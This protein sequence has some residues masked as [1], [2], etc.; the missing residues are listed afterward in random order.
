MRRC[1]RSLAVAFIL[2]F[3]CACGDADEV[4]TTPRCPN[5]GER[6]EDA[7]C[8]ENDGGAGGGD[9]GGRCP[10]G[11]RPDGAEGCLDAG[12]RDDGCSA[13]ESATPDGCEPAGVPQDAC[14]AG[15]LWVDRSCA[16]ILP[17]EPCPKGEIAQLGQIACTEVASCGVGTW[18]DIAV[19]ASSIYV[20]GSH[21]GQST[22]SASQP[23]K[24]IQAAVDAA[25]GGETIAIAAGTYDEDVE[26]EGKTVHLWGRCP[27][28]VE[29]RG[30]ATGNA[31]LFFRAGAHDSSVHTLAVT[32]GAIGVLASGSENLVLDRLWVH[33]TASRGINAQN[34]FGVTGITVRESLVE[35]VGAV[36]IF[37]GASGGIVEGTTVRAVLS[38]SNLTLGRGIV[39][40]YLPET[41]TRA[42]ATISSTVVDT[43][44]DT[45]IFVVGSDTT[46]D[47]TL[48][49]NTLPNELDDRTGR[50]IAVQH[51]F[52]AAERG[53]LTLTRSVI[54]DNR[55]VGFFV[56][57]SDA[58]VDASVIASTQPDEADQ[59]AGGGLQVRYD[60]DKSF[61]ASSLVMS[62]SVVAD[63]HHVGVLVEGSTAEIRSSIVRSTKPQA[64]DQLFGRGIE[65]EDVAEVSIRTSGIVEGSL[66]EDS[67]EM[68]VFAG[69]SDLHIEGT[70][71]RNTQ[72]AAADASLGRGVAAEA[73]L[74]TLAA[75]SLTV[76]A[77]VIEE[78]H[79]L[80]VFISGATA[81]IHGTLIQNIDGARAAAIPGRGVSLQNDAEA[82]RS[83]LSMDSSVVSDVAG[84][85][86]FCDASDLVL[87]GNEIS[88][89]GSRGVNVQSGLEAGSL[90]VVDT[91]V[92]DATEIGIYAEGSTVD[93]MG[94]TVRD[95]GAEP[96]GSFGDGIV[97]VNAPP[98]FGAAVTETAVL[99]SERAAVAAFGA[100]VA[101]QSCT[102]ECNL[103]DLV[104]EPFDVEEWGIDDGGDNACGCDG[105]TRA[106][107]VLSSEMIAPP[108]PVGAN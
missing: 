100:H 28:L 88:A 26:I 36:G 49:R 98:D 66:I 41:D 45:G 108:S 53:A 42:N 82:A 14:G 102:L 61:E 15:F 99:R 70:L 33:D 2:V 105:A 18:G 4:T 52:P 80:G 34:T 84:I 51:A 75:A 54:V 58:S 96:D 97:L 57:G 29:L 63:N 92:A 62:R 10:P 76:E 93:V 25:T 3:P 89:T 86:I 60:E 31:A 48:V 107:K 38:A 30:S 94:V 6:S 12:V 37:I 22:G 56:S 47:S 68:G 32:G 35:D 81:S 44:R 83:S 11:Q 59:T 73:G 50:G 74:T 85:G 90:H 23:H 39:V 65:L 79:E 67:F 17:D 8:S 55:D 72:P 9:E 103:L 43:A 87:E 24:T 1:S 106:C 46:I 64:S 71:I 13:G 21:T 104:G 77:C 16:P 27:G 101:L 91:L 95:T 5:G 20:D 19:D 69:G 7:S 40:E 78:H